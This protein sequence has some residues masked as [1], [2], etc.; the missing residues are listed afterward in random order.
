M[1]NEDVYTRM[2]N[3][4][5]PVKLHRGEDEFSVLCRE[6]PFTTIMRI[7]GEVVSSASEEI[8]KTKDSLIQ[9]IQ[10]TGGL[11]DPT[12]EAFRQ[13]FLIPMISALALEVPAVVE[14]FL[15]DVVV[16]CNEERVKLFTVEDTLSIVSGAVSRIDTERVAELAR[17]VFTQATALYT[18]VLEKQAKKEAVAKKKQTTHK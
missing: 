13:E 12:G 5:F 15:M 2:L 6:I 8:N 7:I 10:Q 14:R 1:A 9:Q 11:I 3:A 16:E 18:K 17:S 4:T